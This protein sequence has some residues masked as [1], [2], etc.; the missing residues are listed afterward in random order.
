MIEYLN[1]G[2]KNTISS[3]LTFLVRI[4]KG[5]SNDTCYMEYKWYKKFSKE[6]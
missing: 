3:I 4:L 1:M 5:I 2:L 6:I